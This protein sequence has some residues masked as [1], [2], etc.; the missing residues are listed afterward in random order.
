MC[1]LLKARLSRISFRKSIKLAARRERPRGG[2]I[3]FVEDSAALCRLGLICVN[4]ADVVR[5]QLEECGTRQIPDNS[6]PSASPL[7]DAFRRQPEN[8]VAV[9]PTGA[10]QRG[11]PVDHSGGQLNQVLA[12]LGLG[13][14]EAATAKKPN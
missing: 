7:D 12:A 2:R 1:F 9:A 4:R 10:A 8:D 14:I 3:E 5:D 13:R 11:Q 6:R